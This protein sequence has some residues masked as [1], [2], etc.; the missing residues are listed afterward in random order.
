MAAEPNS[1]ATSIRALTIA[2]F[3]PSAAAGVLADVRTFNAMGLDASAVITSITFQNVSRGFGAVHQTAAAVR[4]QIDPLLDDF[5]FSCAKTGM[6]PT[7]EI[8]S[9]VAR[10]FR[11]TKLP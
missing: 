4:S 10:L 6:L 8:V 3:D 5:A 2:G 1:P 9:E 11:E 7:A